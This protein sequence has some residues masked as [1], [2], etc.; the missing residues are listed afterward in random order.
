MQSTEA[1]PD[2][3]L[4]LIDAAKAGSRSAFTKI[5]R[6]YQERLLRFLLTRCASHADAEDA[7]QDTFVNA[8]RYLESYDPRWRFSTWIYRIAIRNAM[9]QR[10]DDGPEPDE[11]GDSRGDPLARCIE[12]SERKN[13][14]L[15]AKRI[16]TDEVF[17]A[18]WLRY[19]EDLSV[20]DVASALDRSESWAKVNL[21]RGRQ[22][23][24]AE[25]GGGS[26]GGNEAYG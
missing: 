25:L 4:A 16:L 17:V 14:W 12:D 3:E 10:I 1:Q 2:D 23:L 22:A 8:Y 13:L 6:R 15:S 7:L 26:A 20:R 19:V 18:M 5:V 9:R 24:E 21:M 11:I